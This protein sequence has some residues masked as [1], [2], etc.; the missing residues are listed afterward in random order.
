MCQEIDSEWDDEP[1]DGT[2]ADFRPSG[3][4][5]DPVFERDLARESPVVADYESVGTESH[6]GL[7]EGCGVVSACPEKR[8][9]PE[10]VVNVARYFHHET[11][12]VRGTD[13]D[14][15]SNVRG[16]IYVSTAKKY[17]LERST[18]PTATVT[19]ST[20]RKGRNTS[21]AGKKRSSSQADAALPSSK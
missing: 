12:Q 20:S 21:M 5:L 8:G 16:G 17:S 10:R 1:E 15:R 3:P 18:P 19:A 4:P 13:D 6:G 14:V 9:V 2:S 7:A 11:V